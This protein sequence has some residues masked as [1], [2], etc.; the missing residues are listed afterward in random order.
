MKN[1]GKKAIYDRI[2]NYIDFSANFT[3]WGVS[4]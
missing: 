2:A 3:S 4:K 1:I